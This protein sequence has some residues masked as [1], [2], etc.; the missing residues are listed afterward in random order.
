MSLHNNEMPKKIGLFYISEQT[1]QEYFSVSIQDHN[2]D[3]IIYVGKSKPININKTNFL[4]DSII[5]FNVPSFEI[6]ID[7]CKNRFL[8][9]EKFMAQDVSS[10]SPQTQLLDIE[11]PKRFKHKT[12]I[13]CSD[14][15]RKYFVDESQGSDFASAF[16]NRVIMDISSLTAE[17]TAEQIAKQVQSENNF[18]EIVSMRYPLNLLAFQKLD[19]IVK[20]SV[21]NT[22]QC[23]VPE[24]LKKF[25]A[26]LKTL[27]CKVCIYDYSL[28]NIDIYGPLLDNDKFTFE[29]LPY[30]TTNAGQ[31]ALMYS[32]AQPK[33]YDFA[34]C[35]VLTEYRKTQIEAIRQKGYTVNIIQNKWALERDKE[36]V[37]CAALL[38]IHQ[39]EHHKIYEAC[40]CERLLKAGIPVYS[41]ECIDY[42][43]TKNIKILFK[44]PKYIIYVLCHSEEVFTKAKENYSEYKN[45][46]PILM[47]Y[48]DDTYENAFW[49]Q[50]MEIESEWNSLDYVGTISAKANKKINIDKIDQEIKLSFKNNEDFVHFY[51]TKIPFFHNAHPYLSKI[52]ISV[53]NE[54]KL[55]TTRFVWACNY[56][57]CRV[58]KMANF[59]N[60]NLNVLTPCAQKHPKINFD[61]KYD[62]NKYYS[63]LCFVIERLNPCYFLK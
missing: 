8:H 7:S 56:W 1:P 53:K 23:T 12:L 29:H 15:E 45:L 3:A 17:Q 60:W 63:H 37:K 50:L 40:R 62:K 41:Q 47:K 10:D 24:I 58:P 32:K 57:A 54:L 46:K 48:Q 42:I 2:L 16:T 6:L 25:V 13:L 22:E 9:L 19:T 21:F 28:A 30:Q 33:T 31:L 34:H 27:S 36:I 61:A 44:D 5:V 38:N 4:L 43:P 39:S 49:K 35:G 11:L 14:W 20:L 59:I 18:K 26:D 51:K 55:N 52:L